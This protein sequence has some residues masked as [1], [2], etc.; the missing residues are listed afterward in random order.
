MISVTEKRFSQEVSRPSFF[1]RPRHSPKVRRLKFIDYNKGLQC[2][3]CE[4]GKYQEGN[5][6]KECP[7]G[8]YQEDAGATTCNTCDTT[9][10]KVSENTGAIKCTKCD[11]GK[12]WNGVAE[13]CLVC[14]P[15]EYI[16]RSE[17]K[18]QACSSVQENY[19][20]IRKQ[21]LLEFPI[22]DDYDN[23]CDDIIEDIDKSTEDDIYYKCLFESFTNETQYCDHTDR[24]YY[25]PDTQK[26]EQCDTPFFILLV[27]VLYLLHAN[28]VQ[29]SQTI[30]VFS[31][32][33]V[34]MGRRVPVVLAKNVKKENTIADV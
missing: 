13:K 1:V 27:G 31:C 16:D 18:C 25:S 9:Q 2:V 23:R 11:Y 6:C 34:H 29:Y 14:K 7:K 8:E 21:I 20:T 4:S 26:C 33:G 22:A 3:A 24:K 30:T 5:E 28:Q 17:Y 10:G 19:C 15:G 32:V 12:I